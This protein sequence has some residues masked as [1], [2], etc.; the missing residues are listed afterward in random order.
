M[1]RDWQ[2]VSDLEAKAKH[3]LLSLNKLEVRL[4]MGT[5]LAFELYVSV[6]F[7]CRLCEDDEELETL[8][9]I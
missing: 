7:C 4:I 9:H 5:L 8:E 6:A 3:F 2:P 1:K